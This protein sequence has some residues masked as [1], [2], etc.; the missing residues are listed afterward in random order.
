[1]NLVVGTMA[2]TEDCIKHQDRLA[3]G[4]LDLISRPC[5]QS[6]W[7]TV[8][9]GD[10][11][12]F[13][14]GTGGCVEANNT[15]HCLC[16]PSSVAHVICKICLPL[17]LHAWYN[18]YHILPSSSSKEIE[19]VKNYLLVVPLLDVPDCRWHAW[20]DTWSTQSIHNTIPPLMLFNDR[21][22]LRMATSIICFYVPWSHYLSF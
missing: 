22:F 15:L 14:D 2:R 18:I 12:I 13:E 5:R 6:Q 3:L 10:L 4:Y 1:M 20:C 11:E 7:P 8:T 17:Y 16:A 21:L 9:H 19:G